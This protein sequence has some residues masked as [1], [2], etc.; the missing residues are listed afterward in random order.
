MQPNECREDDE[1]EINSVDD[2]TFVQK[3]ANFDFDPTFKTFFENT[4]SD[5]KNK[6]K[7][8]NSI[9]K[10]SGVNKNNSFS[11]LRKTY[12]QDEDDDYEDDEDEL[13]LEVTEKIKKSFSI[14]GLIKNDDKNELQVFEKSRATAEDDDD[15]DLNLDNN[16]LIV[17]ENSMSAS[18]TPSD[19]VSKKTKVK[20]QSSLNLVLFYIFWFSIF[21]WGFIIILY[22]YLLIIIKLLYSFY[23][24]NG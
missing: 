20:S 11:I 10:N 18:L 13:E 6:I 3:M 7:N 4:D 9:T 21:Y 2:D 16:D 5:S 8:N 24:L 17:M 12:N 1:E 22:W 15:D 19:F 23:Y 14:E